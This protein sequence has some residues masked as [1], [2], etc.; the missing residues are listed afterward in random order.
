MKDPLTYCLVLLKR[1]LR[2]RQE[3]IKAMKLKETSIE[4]I[5]RIITDLESNGLINDTHFAEAWVRT[6]DKLAPRGKSLLSAELTQKGVPKSI[7]QEVL[8]NREDQAKDE[9]HDQ[10]TEYDLAKEIVEGRTRVYSNLT[11]EVRNR[12]LTSLLLRR[13]FSYG[14]IRRILET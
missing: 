14:T 13:G 4:D 3:L 8:R 1:R 7:I 9:E 11:S 5:E 10:P 12:R 6:R 2:T